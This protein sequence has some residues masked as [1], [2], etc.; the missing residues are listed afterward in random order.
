MSEVESLSRSEL[1]V[2]KLLGRIGHPVGY[3][4]LAI[5]LSHRRRLLREH[6]GVVVQ[7]LAARGLIS[8]DPAPGQP[9]GTYQLTAAGQRYLDENFPASPEA[10]S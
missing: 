7:T 2:L 5:R 4:G 8:H 6:L 3:F 9:F 1:Q 10:S